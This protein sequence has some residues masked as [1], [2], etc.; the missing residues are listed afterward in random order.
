MSESRWSKGPGRGV[1][2]VT[3]A[4]GSIQF[5]APFSDPITLRF[6]KNGYV[7][8][9]ETFR[10]YF[11]SAFIIF[12][13]LELSSP[14]VNMAGD[15]TLQFTADRACEDLP[16][17]VRTRTYH[18]ALTPSPCYRNQYYPAL[19]GATLYPTH[20]SFTVG[21]AGSFARFGIY[22]FYLDEWPEF[23][24]VEELTPRGG[25]L[26]GS[27]TIA[28]AGEADAPD[29]GSSFSTS[30]KGGFEYCPDARRSD[31]YQCDVPAVRCDSANHTL[32]VT[33]H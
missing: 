33:R 31:P 2:A 6:S 26:S 18:A 27:A 11:G 16:L 32:A 5:S 15:Y 13:Y 1:F 20:I 7:T 29:G 23:G 17:A 9:T 19:R 10:V 3:N 4:E 24:I 25:A 22:R 14:S 12:F 8:R 30:L 21:V 28:I